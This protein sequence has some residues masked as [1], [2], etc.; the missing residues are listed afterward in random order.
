MTH[1]SAYIDPKTLNPYVLVVSPSKER[2]DYDHWFQDPER[3]SSIRERQ[4]TIMQKFQMQTR[5]ASTIKN[6]KK[7]KTFRRRC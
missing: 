6:E 5:V 4:E 1:L 7:R 2:I 3:P